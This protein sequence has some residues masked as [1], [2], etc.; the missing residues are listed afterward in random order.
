MGL[1]YRE[2]IGSLYESWTIGIGRVCAEVCR[3]EDGGTA[4]DTG[5]SGKWQDKDAYT[6]NSAS[7]RTRS[8]MAKRDTGGYVYEQGGP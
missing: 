3:F 6:P 4:F 5:G 1:A 8:S 7:Y 2:L